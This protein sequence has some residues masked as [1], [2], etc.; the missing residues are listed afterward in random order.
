LKSSRHRA[1]RAVA[2]AMTADALAENVPPQ[3]RVSHTRFWGCF[4]VRSASF[5]NQA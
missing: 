1:V 2:N 5:F 3:H 4:T